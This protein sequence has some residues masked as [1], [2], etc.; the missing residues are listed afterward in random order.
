[1]L[2][3]DANAFANPL[4][5]IRALGNHFINLLS[6]FLQCFALPKT[7]HALRLLLLLLCKVRYM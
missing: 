1:M 5:S 4:G 7:H 6:Y 3:F 2:A